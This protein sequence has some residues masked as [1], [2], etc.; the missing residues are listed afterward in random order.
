MMNIGAFDTANKSH[1]IPKKRLTIGP[2]VLPFHAW[3]HAITGTGRVIWLK[4]VSWNDV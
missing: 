2:Q 1:L 4:P 3:C